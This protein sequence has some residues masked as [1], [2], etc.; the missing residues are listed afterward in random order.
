MLRSYKLIFQE[1]K[2]GWVWKLA[3]TRVKA[4][5]VPKVLA[6]SGQG[7]SSKHHAKRA[8]ERLQGCEWEVG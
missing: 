3:Y 6:K 4:N 1:T 5:M 8:F 2:K 7:Y